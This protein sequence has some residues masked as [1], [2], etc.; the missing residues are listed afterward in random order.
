MK[1]KDEK[2]M[3][4][5]VIGSGAAG[6]CAAR[7][8]V[9]DDAFYRVQVYEQ[10]GC[11][12]GTWVYNEATGLDPQTKQPIHSSMYRNLHTNLPLNIMEFPDFPVKGDDRHF[13]S[14]VRVLKYLQDY[15]SHFDLYPVINF[16]HQVIQVTKSQ[17][18]WTVTVNNLVKQEKI[19]EYFD[20]VVVATGRYSKPKVP[21]VKGLDIW[22]GKVSHTHDYRKPDEFSNQGVF[23]LGGGPSAVDIANEISTRARKVYLCHLHEP[24]DL[25]NKVEQ[26]EATIDHVDARAIHLTNGKVIRDV[27][28]IIF[29]T[30]YKFHYPFLDESSGVKVIDDVYVDGLYKHLI[31]IKEPSMAFFSIPFIL[32]PFPIFHQQVCFF[33]AVLKAKYKLP[34]K[35]EML[36]DTKSDLEYRMN[37]LSLPLRYCHRMGGP[38]MKAYDQFLS[39]AAQIP[40]ISDAK[41]EIFNLLLSF[42]KSRT[43]TYRKLQFEIKSNNE[44]QVYDP[45]VES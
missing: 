40:P 5:C 18:K 3:S 17:N 1:G 31:S 42:Y 29:A 4:V 28:E 12:G 15:A 21:R 2:R 8:F 7:H 23:V 32:L 34:S 39:S 35:E 14:H 27:D 24:Y 38:L 33:V 30:G 13:V 9:H 36:R 25:T 16:Y 41:Q 20:A 26:I 19:T 11:I 45:T 37:Q 22:Q 43:R 10:T 6:L 44:Y